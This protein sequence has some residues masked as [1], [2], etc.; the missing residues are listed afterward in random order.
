MGVTKVI[1]LV[2]KRR[3]GPAFESNVKTKLNARYVTGPKPYRKA[4]AAVASE[5][6]TFET[7]E[8]RRIEDLAVEAGRPAEV[9]GPR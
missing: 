2:T 7:Y 3:L 6:A 8:Q 9:V 5:L 4:L 1:L